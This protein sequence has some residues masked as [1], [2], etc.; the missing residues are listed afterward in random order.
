MG[1]FANVRKFNLP[2]VA[3]SEIEHAVSH[4]REECLLSISPFIEQFNRVGFRFGVH[5][6]ELAIG[7]STEIGRH[8]LRLATWP[9]V[10]L[11]ASA[12]DRQPVLPPRG[13]RPVPLLPNSN[14]LRYARL[15]G[16]PP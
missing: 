2:V 10:F 8:E 7:P 4:T 15:T 16:V 11:V 3:Q 6:G 5:D 14:S 1:G 12:A 13:R 9:R